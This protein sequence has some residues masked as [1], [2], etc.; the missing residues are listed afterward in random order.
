MRVYTGIRV[1]ECTYVRFTPTLNISYVV[2]E[3]NLCT[4]FSKKFFS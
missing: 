4:T 2:P 1:Y 3:I